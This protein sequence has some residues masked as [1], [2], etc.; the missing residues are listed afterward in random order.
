MTILTANSFYVKKE[1]PDHPL[2]EIHVK[3]EEK[4]SH[5]C[6]RASPAPKITKRRRS[7]YRPL[8]GTVLDISNIPLQPKTLNDCLQLED[9]GFLCQSLET[10]KKIVAITGAGISVGS[11]IP[12]FRSANGLFQGFASKANG[13][14]KNLF[15]YNVFRSPE[16]LKEFEKMIRKLYTLSVECQPSPFH[17]L[18]DKISQEG[19]LLRLYT[20]NI[21]CLDTQL[22]HLET[23]VPLN[24]EKPYPKTIQLHGNIK[25]LN[26]SKCHHVKE[27][28]ESYFNE[29]SKLI[30]NCPEC[31]ELNAV[32]AIAGRRVQSGGV[33]RPRIVLYNEFH[34]DGE[35]I[36][37]ITESDLKNRP[38]CLLVV[39]TTLKIPGVR[40]LVKEMAKVVHSKN[41]SVIWINIEEPTQSIVDY[42]E[43][44]DLIV[45]GSCQD[46][47]ALLDAFQDLK[48]K[49]KQSKKV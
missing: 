45:T 17:R 10:S 29:N 42:V 37:N 30:R 13:S 25:L 47:P 7:R 35:I 49:K 1:E 36:G 16:S 14:G 9:I 33:L 39:G 46:I 28:D 20:Q 44:F 26:C 11:G 43:H 38:D 4:P 18:L 32:R 15:D 8:N 31:E 48:P 23:K 40:R 5:L 2:D 12:D 21:D 6:R 34:P 41:G 24:F 3:E 27:L 19:R 22:P